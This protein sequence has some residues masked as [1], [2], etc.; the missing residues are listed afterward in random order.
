MLMKTPPSGPVGPSLDEVHDL[1]GRSLT[2]GADADPIGLD[3]TT[4]TAFSSF[5]FLGLIYT[6]LLRWTPD[7]KIEPD[8]AVSYERPTD[9]SYVFKLRQGVKFHNGKD[10]S[11]EDVKH[12]FD[13]ILD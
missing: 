9:T 5:D 3:P 10:F 8:L 4:V 13:R 6:G 2:I 12:T 11:A 7:M 1:S